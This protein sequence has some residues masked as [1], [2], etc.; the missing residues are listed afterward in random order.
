M[1]FVELGSMVC[2]GECDVW[3]LD[4]WCLESGSVVCA[5][6]SVVFVGGTCD[7]WRLVLWRVCVA[8]GVWR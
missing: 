1:L 5:S 3:K 4:R 7:V 6:G 2:C 8:V